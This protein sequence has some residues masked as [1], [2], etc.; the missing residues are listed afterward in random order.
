MEGRHHRLLHRLGD[1]A[2]EPARTWHKRQMDCQMDCQIVRSREPARTWHKRQMDCQIKWIYM[3][4]TFKWIVGARSHC[5]NQW[6]SH[7]LQTKLGIQCRC[8]AHKT[9]YSQQGEVTCLNVYIDTEI[10]KPYYLDVHE[11]WMEHNKV[12]W[13]IKPAAHYYTRGI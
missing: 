2:R 3:A 5:C 10:C 12:N 13:I 1:G 9:I 11:T 7:W 6:L 4:Q 8:C